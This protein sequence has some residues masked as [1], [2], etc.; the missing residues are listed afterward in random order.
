MSPGS[1]F[2]PRDRS[3]ASV[4]PQTSLRA[5]AVVP[6]Y[7]PPVAHGHRLGDRVAWIDGDDGAVQQD[8]V[9][10][11]TCTTAGRISS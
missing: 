1:P 9:Q 2:V 4:P 6:T 5:A 7:D 11:T 10:E 3:R 8:D